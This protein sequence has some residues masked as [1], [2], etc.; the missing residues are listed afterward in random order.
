VPGRC[1][2]AAHD[3]G[4][5]RFVHQGIPMPAICLEW[6]M[7]PRYLELTP[8]VH[9]H[10]P[11]TKTLLIAFSGLDDFR[12]DNGKFDYFSFT[13]QNDFD[14]VL[15][16]DINCTWYQMPL[17]GRPD[18]RSLLIEYLTHVAQ[19]Y[20]RVITMGGSMGG[21]AAIMF[22]RLLDA[23]LALP[24]APQTCIYS[25]PGKIVGDER[26]KPRFERIEAMGM[27]LLY[28][29]L[30]DISYSSRLKTIAYVPEDDSYDIAHIG[31]LEGQPDVNVVL[32][33]RVGHGLV[34]PIF[35]SGGLHEMI[36]HAAV[37][38]EIFDPLPKLRSFVGR[39]NHELKVSDLIRLDDVRNTIS[40][41]TVFDNRSGMDWTQDSHPN[42]MVRARI[43]E[44]GSPERSRMMKPLFVER[45]EAGGK[46]QVTMDVDVSAFP[47][48][49]YFV[50]VDL[51]F[52]MMDSSDIGYLAAA[53][54]F[55]LRKSV[56]INTIENLGKTR[57]PFEK[58]EEDRFGRSTWVARNAPAMTFPVSGG[59]LMT[60][61]GRIDHGVITANG[62]GEGFIAFGPFI[63]LKRGFYE[64]AFDVDPET[65]EGEM[66]IDVVQAPDTL[67]ARKELQVA[68]GRAATPIS[69]RFHVPLGAERVEVRMYGRWGCRAAVNGLSIRE[70]QRADEV[71]QEELLE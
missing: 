50:A 24:F 3:R 68:S 11:G 9:E 20:D 8:A 40:V 17:P 27:P 45:A 53:I 10:L 30:R 66:V 65:T 61:S 28:A 71:A 14:V 37:S 5:C 33:P 34:N 58:V 38:D 7:L 25:E 47:V 43:F 46:I 67:F 49:N 21:F 2:A 29:D 62:Q 41:D 22:G 54:R 15:V 4:D 39:Y 64:A 6:P 32:I 55:D 60:G 18:S 44:I 23:D 36:K 26:F 57:R 1:S 51:Q 12:K 19:N 70:V 31:R 69:I 52:G 48:G 35:R 63:P 56:Y 13:R 42:T 16:R 59:L